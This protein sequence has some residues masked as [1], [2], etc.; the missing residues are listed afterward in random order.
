MNFSH[1]RAT[2]Y[3]STAA[4]AK[5]LASRRKAARS[6]DE[7]A[8]QNQRQQ[9]FGRGLSVPCASGRRGQVYLQIWQNELRGQKAIAAIGLKIFKH[10]LNAS[11]LGAP[12]RLV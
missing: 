4:I 6:R 7:R 5:Q 3:I 11:P 2:Q 10:K 1:R 12:R 9:R 8:L